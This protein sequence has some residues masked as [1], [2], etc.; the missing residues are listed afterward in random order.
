MKLMRTLLVPALCLGLIATLPGCAGRVQQAWDTVTTVE[1][2]R[3]KIIA[4]AHA[5][6][7]LQATA[8]NYIRLRRCTGSNGPICRNQAVADQIIVAVRTGRA[9]RNSLTVYLR[10]NPQGGV[11]ASGLYNALIS[12][13]T[14]LRELTAGR[15]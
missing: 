8:T 9:A 11:G 6:N 4:A 13:N 3:D 5:F 12:S 10:Q 7:A 14:T 15:T 2:P 1:V